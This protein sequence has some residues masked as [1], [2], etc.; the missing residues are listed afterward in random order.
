MDRETLLRRA[1]MTGSWPPAIS[2]ASRLLAEA[3]ITAVELTEACLERIAKHDRRINA[4]H[5]VLRDEALTAAKESDRRRE[6][7]RSRG[8][9]DGIPV[10][11]KDVIQVEGQPCTAN[12][13][14]LENNVAAGD[15][16]A[17][18]RLRA[19]GAVIVGLVDTYE[20]AFGG[21]PTFDAL[22]P[23]ARNP[24][25]D[26]RGTGG[27]SSGCGAAVAAGFCLGAVGSDAGGSIRLPAALCGISGLKPTI[28]RVSTRGV[29]PLT[30]SLDTVGPMA[31]TA[32]DCALML[33]AMAG[34]DSADP[35]SVDMPVPEFSAAASL[36]GVRIGYVRH[37]HAEDFE[38]P[39]DIRRAVDSVAEILAG[40][41]AEVAEARLPP[42]MDFHAAGRLILPAEAFAIHEEA[43]R[44]RWREFGPLARNRMMLGALVRA[45]DYLQAQRMR[46][47][48]T[49][50]VD[51]VLKDV[52]ALVC[53]AMLTP[54]A[55]MDSA[56]P[57]PFLDAPMINVAFNLTD[58]PAVTVRCGFQDDGMPVGAQ[59]AA[60]RR[61]EATALRVADAYERAVGDRNRRPRL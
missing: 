22:F 24:W 21:R 34:Y 4:F 16:E 59:V 61:D 39:G 42:L 5:R 25:N 57:F 51:A 29:V 46:Q 1:E 50:A 11:V 15:A 53:A 32:E 17:V 43:L 9:L 10:A 45:V 47:E 56:E 48:L 28:G 33:G 18:R 58:H 27:S 54:A 6:V 38:A 36:R 52:D 31:W 20:F 49:E 14:L 60:R 41:G 35:L 13:R 2:E 12:S 40:C 8:P 7:G 44:S 30:F 19:A 55:P 26:E 37:F 3:Q 23:P